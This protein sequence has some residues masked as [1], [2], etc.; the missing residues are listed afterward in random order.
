MS[1]AE[2]SLAL[3]VALVPYLIDRG[4]ATVAEAAEHFEVSEDEIRSGV[5]LLAMSGIPDRDGNV[6]A[7][8]MFDIAWD[9]FEDD[10]VIEL[11]HLVA[12]ETSPR[13]GVREASALIA[14]LELVVTAGRVDRDAVRTLQEKLR[15]AT[16]GAHAPLTVERR[17]G[18]RH[19]DSRHGDVLLDAIERGEVVE[20]QYR[21][22]GESTATRHVAPI[23]LELIDTAVFLRAFDLDRDA[24][25]SFRVDRIESV[26]PTDRPAPA[27]AHDDADAPVFVPSADAIDVLVDTTV[28][29]AALLDRYASGAPE[30]LA[31]GRVRV[32][33]RTARIDAVV[34]AIAGLGGDAVIVSPPSARAH[35]LRF[36]TRATAAYANAPSDPR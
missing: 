14:G 9:Q 24:V 28:A 11:T 16:T 34:R 29:G 13:L 35:M 8:D 21:K 6:F 12:L 31:D 36:V 22:P 7:N 2:E 17:G 3:L 20:M 5:R 25:R 32:C 18:S 26:T 27:H 19:G 1:Q 33:I 30:S 10:D 15:R 4:R 23:R